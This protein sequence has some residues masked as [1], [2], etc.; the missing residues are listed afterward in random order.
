[1]LKNYMLKI[2][3]GFTTIVLA[4]CNLNYPGKNLQ[5]TAA[6]LYS[7]EKTWEDQGRPSNF[8]VDKVIGP[9]GVIFVY[10]NTIEVT[11]VVYHCH[12][13]A[14][15]P[16]WPDG[17]MVIADNQKIFWIRARDGKITPDPMFGG[18]ER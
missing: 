10:T 3:L 11:N 6:S 8:D 13:A 5:G 14:R 17:V 18:I 16:Y 1:M 9:P 4:G 2:W 12:F 15:R 7:V